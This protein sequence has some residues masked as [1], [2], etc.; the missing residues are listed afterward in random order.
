MAEKCGNSKACLSK[1]GL[2]QIAEAGG[3]HGAVRHISKSNAGKEKEYC[4]LENLT[5][6]DKIPRRHGFKAAVFPVKIER[7][8]GARV[9][10]AAFG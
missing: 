8:S 6:L 4:N 9:R 2:E 1:T 3:T 7:A 10:V 5:S